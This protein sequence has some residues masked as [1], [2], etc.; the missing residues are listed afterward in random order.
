M[1]GEIDD[2]YV[3]HYLLWGHGKLR[4][5]EADA[6]VDDEQLTLCAGCERRD[7]CEC[8]DRGYRYQTYAEAMLR[9][10]TFEM[11]FLS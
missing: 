4:D 11:D 8:V 5:K 9:D 1:F 6:L 10:P 3:P 2:D 7:E